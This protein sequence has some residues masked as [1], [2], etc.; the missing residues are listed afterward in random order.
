MGEWQ[1]YLATNGWVILD[2]DSQLPVLIT[3]DDTADEMVR[4]IVDAHNKAVR[5]ARAEPAHPPVG[6]LWTGPLQGVIGSAIAELFG[7]DPKT[8]VAVVRADSIPAA[9]REQVWQTINWLEAAVNLR[10]E[11]IS[12]QATGEAT[13]G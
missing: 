8:E 9:T 3:K 2:K 6:P 13:D 4:S 12:G 5:D 1:T 7:H 11:D 10:S